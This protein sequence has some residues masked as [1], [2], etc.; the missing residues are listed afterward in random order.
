METTL[1]S[2]T[3]K[4]YTC[5]HVIQCKY[6]QLTLLVFITPSVHLCAAHH[7]RDEARVRIADSFQ[8]IT[9]FNYSVA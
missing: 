5:W 2:K 9:K 6:C 1:A 4:K 8:Q 3:V 7:W